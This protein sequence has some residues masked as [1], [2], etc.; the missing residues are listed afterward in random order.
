MIWK[1]PFEHQGKH[2]CEAAVLGCIDF[3]FRKAFSRFVHEGLGIEHFDQAGVPGG[4]K[5][6]NDNH[7]LAHA[8]LSVP[9][10]LHDAQKLILINHADC[11]AYGGLK[12]FAGNKDEEEAFH[13]QELLKAKASLAKEYPDKEIITVFAKLDDEQH[14]QFIKVE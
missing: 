14:I 4:A 12:R 2:S 11:G 1:T 6:I 8:C 5:T 13:R 10:E 7:D 9:C 3:R